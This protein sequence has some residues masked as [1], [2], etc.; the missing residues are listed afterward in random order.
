MPYDTL[1][2]NGRRYMYSAKNPVSCSHMFEQQQGLQVQPPPHES[3]PALAQFP[4]LHGQPLAV[5]S[6]AAGLA[7]GGSGTAAAGAA[8][9]MGGG[10]GMGAD[11]DESS[12]AEANAP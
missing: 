5:V 10:G 6:L 4:E 1:A 3:Q 12:A 2:P 9:I 8:G 11:G 7:I